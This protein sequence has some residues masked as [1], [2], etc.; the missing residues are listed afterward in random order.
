MMRWTSK[1]VVRCMSSSSSG[2]LGKDVVDKIR[3][4]KLRGKGRSSLL[5]GQRLVKMMPDEL[6]PE[7]ET[8][9]GVVTQDSKDRASEDS[10]QA[11]KSAVDLKMASARRR[12]LSP[13]ERLAALMPDKDM[14]KD[15]ASDK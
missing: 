15:P 4:A 1:I 7:Q 11:E 13:A 3:M 8:L 2:G 12:K 9:G 6:K 10:I 5:P 14:D